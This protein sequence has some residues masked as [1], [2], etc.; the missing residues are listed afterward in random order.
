MTS[1]L[2]Q[3]VTDAL[4]TP[5]WTTEH[6]EEIETDGGID[7]RTLKIICKK[8]LFRRDVWTSVVEPLLRQGREEFVIDSESLREVAETTKWRVDGRTVKIVSFEN[9]ITLEAEDGQRF[10]VTA[11]LTSVKVRVVAFR[12]LVRSVVDLP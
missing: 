9:N 1:T 11:T 8:T 7:F 2:L 6:G 3:E 4:C 10:N 5:V 12:E